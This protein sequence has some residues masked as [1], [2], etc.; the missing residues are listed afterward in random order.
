MTTREELDA[1]SSKEL[2][3]RAFSEAKRHM[4]VGF[5]WQLLRSLPAAE[6]AIV[7]AQDK[8][9]RQVR[10]AEQALQAAADARVAEEQRAAKAAA[11]AARLLTGEPLADPVVEPPRVSFASRRCGVTPVVS[12]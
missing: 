2:H 9:A 7:A 4:D 3:D 8:A 12:S 5:F 1:L 11:E 10:A 6:A